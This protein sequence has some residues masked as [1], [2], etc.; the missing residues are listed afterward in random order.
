VIGTS[1]SPLALPKSGALTDCLLEPAGPGPSYDERVAVRTRVVHGIAAVVGSARNPAPITLDG[2][3][4]RRSLLGPAPGDV[5]EPFAWNARRAR[6]QLGL[7]AARACA[8][9]RARSLAQG[10]TEAIEELVSAARVGRQK[11]GSLGYWLAT[12]PNGARAMVAAEALTWATHV[13]EALQWR[14]F[15]PPAVI[16]PP[17]RWWNCPGATNV[18]LRARSDVLALSVESHPKEVPGLQVLSTELFEPGPRRVHLEILPG[19]PASTYRSELGLI[20][21]V[22][23]LAHPSHPAP[24]RVV[25]WWPQS[26]RAHVFSI[27]R[28]VLESTANA[29]LGA[30]DT[31]CSPLSDRLADRSVLSDRPPAAA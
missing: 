21:L 10:V 5:D 7:R 19:R 6:R 24:A 15:S 11:R 2:F 16:G 26:G 1:L 3:H 28:R 29:V 4:L 25:G 23:V 18:A 31:V 30:I 20:A 13:F 12:V 27:D 14:R 17:D 8:E 22:D 9:G